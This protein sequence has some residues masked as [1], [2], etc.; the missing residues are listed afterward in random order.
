MGKR[1]GEKTERACLLPDLNFEKIRQA[2]L[3]YMPRKAPLRDLLKWKAPI[4]IAG[5]WS[6]HCGCGM[7][8]SMLYIICLQK[9][10][11]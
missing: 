5:N 7:S 6:L 11:I 1:R 4:C 8:Y 9:N 10:T 3:L 2:L